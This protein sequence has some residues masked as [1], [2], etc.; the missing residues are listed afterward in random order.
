MKKIILFVVIPLALILG[1]Y[2]IFAK[3]P[4]TS[5]SEVIVTAKKGDFQIDISVT[6]E[7]EAKNS[8]K[9]MGPMALR[10]AGIWDIKIE[11]LVPEGTVVDKGDF[12]AALDKTSL[13]DRINDRATDLEVRQS[14]YTQTRLD[15]AINLRKLRDELINK[16]FD[17][18]T[19]QLELEQSQFEPPATIKTKELEL[20]KAKRGYKQAQ[21]NYKLESEKARSEMRKAYARVK[22]RQEEVDFLQGLLGEMTIK[23]P[24]PGMVIYVKDYR[25]QK[26]IEGAMIR[27]WDPEVAE[28]PDLTTMVSKTFV[29]EVDI[30]QIKEGQEVLIGLDAFPE[31]KLTGSVVS[32]SNV[33]EQKQNSD[34][35]VF[36]V[37]IEVNETDTLLRP[38]M[39]T[40]NMIISDVVSDVI[41]LPLETL[42]SQ[43]D[44]LTYVFKKAGLSVVRKEVEVGKTNSNEAIIL[45]GV[46]VGDNVLLNMPANPEEKKLVLLELDDADTNNL[47]ARE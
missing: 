37:N 21:E 14:D 28:L 41:S 15:T 36:Q 5:E 22:E 25:G 32:V 10:R 18:E 38:S 17:V 40:S 1:I 16:Q 26:K 34:A 46:E 30:R 44:S 20:E 31:K 8:V 47:T 39:T 3:G 19:K 2:F 23:A 24:E 45:N 12:I 42:H 6:G 27:G 35:K 43:G 33:G 7:L 13:V 11:K 29:N 4:A 9:I